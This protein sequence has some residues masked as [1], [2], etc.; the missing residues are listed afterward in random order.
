MESP[1]TNEGVILM[2]R[3]FAATLFM[4]TLSIV[5]FNAVAQAESRDDVIKQIEAKRAE[6]TVLEKRLLAPSEEERNAYAEFIGQRDKGLIR[7][8]PRETYD[9][10]L[11]IRGGGSYYSFVTLTHAYGRGSDIALEQGFLKVGFAGADYGMLLNVGDVPLEDIN[12]EHSTVKFL[13]AYNAVLEEPL[14]RVEQRRFGGGTK[15]DGVMYSERVRAQ[16]KAT[17]VVRSINYSESD[18]LV[19]FRVL[20]KDNDGSL[21]IAWKMLRE[22]PIPDLARNTIQQ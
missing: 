18:V 10:V 15:I 2:K 9:G 5:S 6:L 21:I 14:A 11:A 20:R 8:L 3:V 1:S 7:L 17:Y 13:A 19:A 22:F 12:T 16:V 4:A